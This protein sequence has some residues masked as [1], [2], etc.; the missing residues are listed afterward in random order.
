MFAGQS[1]LGCGRVVGAVGTVAVTT[2]CPG[3]AITDWRFALR[4]V[5]NGPFGNAGKIWFLM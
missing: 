1:V 2:L 4:A 3:F 5:T